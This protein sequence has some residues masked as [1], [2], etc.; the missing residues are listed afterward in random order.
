V[1]TTL[2]SSLMLSV[3]ILASACTGQFD[4]PGGPG[5]NPGE[6]DASPPIIDED[7]PDAALP[8][9]ADT[10]RATAD[11][12]AIWE[13]NEG[14]GP[15]IGDTSNIGNPCDL[16][17]VSPGLTTWTPTGLRIDASTILRNDAPAT[18][19]IDACKLSNEITLEAWITPAT[20]DTGGVQER[21]IGISLD[22]NLR[23]FSLFQVN[24]DYQF[25]LRTGTTSLDGDPPVV[26]PASVS[27]LPQHIVFTRNALGEAKLYINAVEVAT[28]TI[29]DTFATWD[30]TYEFFM[31]NEGTLDRPWMGVY[32][33][34]AVYSRALTASE[35]TRNY[36]NNY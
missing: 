10:G 36:A 9:D 17:V 11:L 1:R 19:I 7:P 21:V 28:A 35:V 12:Q 23:N 24:G 25:A 16:R 26:A 8:P 2:V 22:T 34:V 14:L 3:S 15:D 20:V 27:T 4:G 6:P 29:S 31:A 5:P 30:P 13:F 32:H 33:L 18:K